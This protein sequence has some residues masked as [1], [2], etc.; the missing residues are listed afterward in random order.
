MSEL[1][2]ILVPKIFNNGVEV[3]VSHHHAWDEKVGE[4]AGGLT[5]LKPAT[6]IWTNPAGEIFKEA[7]IPVRIACTEKQIRIIIN[8]TIIHYNQQAVMAYRISGYVILKQRD[9]P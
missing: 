4:I 6:G 9:S 8:F 3:P 1:W 5:I 7:M 2:E